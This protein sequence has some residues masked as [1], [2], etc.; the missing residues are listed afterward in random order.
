ME[1]VPQDIVFKTLK[2]S[3]ACVTVL[4]F[5]CEC[6]CA[7]MTSICVC[8]NLCLHFLNFVCVC[9]QQG[10]YIAHK[11]ESGWQVGVIKTFDKKDPSWVL[12]AGKFNVKFNVKY[13]NH[14][15]KFNVKYKNEL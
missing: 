10:R 15:G 6:V 7:R 14:A 13:K 12:H 3:C 11:F 9:M 5:A 1:D 4:V 2:V 8:E